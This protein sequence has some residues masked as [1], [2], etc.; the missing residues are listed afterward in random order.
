MAYNIRTK[1][2]LQE[3]GI[4]NCTDYTKQIYVKNKRWDPPP[5]PTL[6]EDKITEFEKALKIAHLKQVSKN[7]KRPL[8]NL[9]QQQQ[10]TLKLLYGNKNFTIKPTDKNLD[11]AILDTT[12]Y[13]TQVLKEHLLTKDYQQI[14]HTEVKNKMDNL[15]QLLKSLLHTH[16]HTLSKS[17]ILYFNRSLQE[18]H[19]LPIFYG[20]P[21][22]HKTPMS[23]RP[24]VSS[25]SSLLSV[26]SNWLDFRMKELLPFVQ[27]YLKNSTTVIQDLKNFHLPQGAQL[28]SADAKSMYTNIDT[29]T[30]LKAVQDFIITNNA[31]LPSNFPTELFLQ[32]LKLVME[33]NIFS[34][35]ESYWLQLSGTAMGTPTACSYATV[36]YGH[37][38]NTEI[39]TTFKPNLIYYK[40]YI[41]NVFGI[42]LPP[43]HNKDSTW[44]AFKEKLNSW[45]SLHWTIENPSSHTV[46]LDL[47]IYIRNSKI[48]TTTFQKDLNLYLYLPPLSAHPPSCLKGLINGELRRYWTQNT[49]HEDFQDVLTKF[50]TRLLDRGHTITAL[51]PM[52][53]QA[54]ACLDQASVNNNNDASSKILYIHWP[55]HPNGLKR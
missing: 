29:P 2:Y 8:N 7:A 32:I 20:L 31:L 34:F 49:T 18:Q 6:I 9:T 50:I 53:L 4:S 24:V 19:R 42:W 38:E 11:P 3:S 25:S 37:F 21:K 47:N 1:Y 36:S 15:R 45:G 16:R 35:G 12:S 54:S 39:L 51:A 27:S 23:L 13:A 55:Y 43:S 30:G 5:A 52:L 28:F 14:T 22:V 46:F 10:N 17:E 26:F 41:D 40:R 44:N 48:I 33:N